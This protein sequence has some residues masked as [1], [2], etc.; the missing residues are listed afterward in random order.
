MKDSREEPTHKV[1]KPVL[2]QF[3]GGRVDTQTLRTFNTYHLMVWTHIKT[4]ETITTIM[5][6]DISI[7]KSFPGLLSLLDLVLFYVVRTRD[8]RS[9]RLTGVSCRVPCRYL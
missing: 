3:Y 7:S 5:T 2:K 8:M 6:I 9:T 1:K 4:R